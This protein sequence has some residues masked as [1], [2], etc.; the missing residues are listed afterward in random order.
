MNILFVYKGYKGYKGVLSNAVIDAQINSLLK[1]ELKIIKFPLITSGAF[2]YCTEYIR[3]IRFIRSNKIELIH[4]HYSYSAIISAL[5]GKK[6]ICSLMGS[7]IYDANKIMLITLKFFSKYLWKKTIVKSNRMQQIISNSTVIPNGIDFSIFRNIDKLEAI[8]KANFDSNKKNIIFIAQDIK[9]KVKNF[10]LAEEAV[11]YL[12][13]KDV[14]LHKISQIPQEELVYY[15]NAA[16]LLLLTS[17]SEGSPNVIKE[18]MACNCPII[19]TDV[20]DV[21]ELIADSKNCFI[22]SYSP[23]DIS[24]KIKIILKSKQRS[25]GVLKIQHL[26]SIKISEHLINIYYKSV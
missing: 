25:D 1:K 24:E 21:S 10:K 19:S 11:N 22:A 8:K 16:D 3:L 26:S 15:Y 2:S 9:S 20:G 4:A 18:A 13:N 7:D 23:K 5:T 6:T 14:I 17:L 12:N